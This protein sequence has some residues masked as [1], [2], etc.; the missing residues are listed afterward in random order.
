VAVTAPAPQ[1]PV[2]ETPPAGTGTPPAEQA[3]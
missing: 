2:P 3:A 1:S